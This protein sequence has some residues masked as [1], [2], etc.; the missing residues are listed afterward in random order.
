M[1]DV[2]SMRNLGRVDM[3]NPK[4]REHM[5]QDIAGIFQRGRANKEESHFMMRLGAKNC[6][7]LYNERK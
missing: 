2:L 1:I 3:H 7:I 4:F 5:A 6:R